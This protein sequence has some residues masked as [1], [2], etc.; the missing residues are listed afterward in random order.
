MTM[1]APGSERMYSSAEFEATDHN[2]LWRPR[3]RDPGREH[4]APAVARS[5]GVLAFSAWLWGGFQ[6]VSLC[7][8]LRPAL[9]LR[10]A[11]EA[12]LAMHQAKSV[13]ADTVVVVFA[14]IRAGVPSTAKP[15]PWLV[16]KESTWSVLAGSLPPSIC[17]APWPVSPVGDVHRVALAGDRASPPSPPQTAH[18]NRR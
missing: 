10:T 4:L 18:S 3:L 12:G 2:S 16:E 1:F 5:R 7:K 15:A 6:Q 14:V 11:S 17:M 9:L 8:A 13:L